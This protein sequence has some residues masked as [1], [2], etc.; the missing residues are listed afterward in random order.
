MLNEKP[1][2]TLT[3]DATVETLSQGFHSTANPELVGVLCKCM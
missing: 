1:T 2:K 3:I